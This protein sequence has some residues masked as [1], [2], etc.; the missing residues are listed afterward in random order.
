MSLLILNSYF[1][2]DPRN[3]HFDETEVITL[4][5]EINLVSRKS[6]CSHIILLGE[7]NCHFQRNNRFTN[8]VR[9][10]L[11]D[12]MG[13]TIMWEHPV[14]EP[15]SLI[16]PV[17]YTHLSLV[18]SVP[19]Y[20]TIDH[21]VVSP[22]VHQAVA[23]AN[24]LHC[25]GNPSNHS[26]IYLKLRVGELDLELESPNPES[27]I[28]WDKATEDAR[29]NYQDQ[30]ASKLD[31][32]ECSASCMNCTSFNCISHTED[33]EEYTM[34]VL[35]AIE[36]AGKECLPS[37][38]SSKLHRGRKS[39]VPGWSQH[40]KPYKD[41]CMFWHSI[42]HSAGRP[43][44]GD[45]YL[46]MRHSKNQYKYAVRRLQKAKGKIQNDK[47]VS[48]IMKGGVNIFEEIRKFRGSNST[49]SSRIDEEVGGDNIANHFAGIYSKLYNRVDV[50]DKLDAISS[51]LEAEI[52]PGS[53]IEMN[54]ISERV[55][56]DALN[57]MKA[58]KKDAIHNIVSDMYIN[59]P[60]QL[61]TH[62]T[63]MIRMFIQ[64]GTVPN[65]I[66][67][68]TLIPIVKDNLGDITSSDNYRAIAGGCLL[69]KLIDIVILLL[70]GEKLQVDDLQYGY[71]AMSSTIMC[72]WSVTS[73]IDFYNRGGRPAY[74]CA[75]DMS[76]A[77]DMVEWTELFHTLRARGV[78]AIFLRLLLVIYKNQQ[79]SVKW[80]GKYSQLFGVSNGVRQG[81]VSSAI[82]FSVYIDELFS[83]LR[84]SKLG[85]QISG[86][87]FG[88]F[89]YADDL[90]LLSASRSGLQA[91][92]NICHEFVGSKSLQF[93]TNENP[94]KS[95]TKCL[96]FS[97]KAEEGVNILPV[98]LSGVPL[99]WVSQVKHLGNMLQLDNSMRMDVCQKRGKFIGKMQSLLQE[100]SYVDPHTFM[101]ITNLFNTSF[102]GSSLWDL[103]SND[104]EKLFKSWNVAVRQAFRVHRC[105]HRYLIEPISGTVHPKVELLA[106][107]VT[108]YKSLKNST[109][110]GLR[111]L[112][113]LAER[114]GR[115]IMGKTLN[116]LSLLC[117]I[118]D[119]MQLTS[120]HVKKNLAYHPVPIGELWRI[121][122]VKELIHSDLEGFS[123][124]EIIEMKDFICRS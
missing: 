18:R 8:L 58:N 2:C 15:Y 93:S 116:R 83:L 100:F 54:R 6:S 70:E 9:N 110:L 124:E 106:R 7:L 53:D 77:F 30:L 86:V 51:E 44:H 67:L 10:Y 43:H 42:W 61:L 102:Y 79:C 108:F 74:G 1:P 69:L 66:L 82:L 32:I 112:V 24:V 63:S 49:V 20:S 89:G 65:F 4:L 72:T 41:E 28:S 71:Q 84:K 36:T 60:P 35:E 114:D 22:Q 11:E 17:D 96:I 38:G 105:T 14:V 123:N 55:V 59:G 62:L 56:N 5:E 76:K 31:L 48:S 117:S 68:C 47:F 50:K 45:I 113:R 46:N 99:P 81:A 78:K 25:G 118:N 21:F 13:L 119:I 120:R 3:D 34:Q 90:F 104:C 64:H 97:K 27:R 107:F 115:T 57:R 91:M 95:K 98:K 111:L 12:E 92:V 40:V 29:L 52:G 37:T 26:P 85:C 39:P 109:K 88:C 103:F 101:R 19:A 33:L 73:V 23:E 16:Q 122:I 80:A 121:S 75:M 94:V 87:Y